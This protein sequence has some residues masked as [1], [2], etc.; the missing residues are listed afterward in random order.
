MTH[1]HRDVWDICL[2]YIKRNVSEKN[3]KTWFEPIRSVN[4]SDHVL[5]LQV[6]NKFFFEWLE[7]NYVDLLKKVITKNIG[8]DA[9]LEYQILVDNHR[10]IG[11]NTSKHVNI[12]VPK[13]IESDEIKNPFVIPGIKK[14]KVDPQLSSD[15][16][17]DKFVVSECNRLAAS[18]GMAIAKKPGMTAFNPLVIYGDTGLGKT[19]IAQA[20]GS[21]ILKENEGQQVLFLTSERFTN[22][23][24]QACKNNSVN[25][26]MNFYLCI[27]TLIIDDIHFFSNRPKTQEIFFNL[28][29]QMHQNNKQIIL[30]MDR[31]PKDLKDVD[32]RLIS[33][34]K[35]GLSAELTAPDF[36]TRLSILESKMKENEISLSR[37]VMEYISHNITNNLRE[38][39]GVL[40]TLGAQ[41]S[42]NR[43]DIDLLLA[44]E[45]VGQ[46][47]EEDNKKITVENIQKMAADFFSV[48]VDKLQGKTRKSEVVVAR[49]VSMYLAK[50]YTEDSLKLIGSQFGGRDHSTVIYSVGAV[51]NR[52]D[53]DE[54][55]K[56]QVAELEKQVQLNLH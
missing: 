39:E 26:F 5:T 8:P 22:Q 28:F 20:I 44:R 45:I 10:L 18:A 15:Y 14:I 25:D 35:W 46:F 23:V 54:T 40:I 34:F 50:N 3:Y 48:T 2:S 9:R 13:K 47:V 43:K 36:D 32:E 7:D 1:D 56:E 17:M 31:P 42:L 19:H 52:M 11:K 24:V 38:L 21:Q 49:Q 27:D 6:P 4:L 55:F 37:D 53:V 29:N 16:T 33:R 30:T 41:A 51:Q 12:E